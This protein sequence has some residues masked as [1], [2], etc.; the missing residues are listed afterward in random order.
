MSTNLKTNLVEEI[1]EIV[2]A[3]PR[4]RQIQLYEFA[5]FLKSHPLP[6]EKSLEAVLEDEAKWNEQFAA[7]DDEK[8]SELVASVEAEIDEGNTMP[9]FDPDGN[10][11][12]PE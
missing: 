8:L 10:F 9:M 6:A 4:A 12:E 1:N 7:T 5:L 2:A 11:V 3:M